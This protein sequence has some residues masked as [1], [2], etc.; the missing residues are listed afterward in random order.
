MRKPLLV[1]LC[2]LALA[3]P[4]EVEAAPLCATGTLQ[5]Y[6]GLTA[7]GCDIGSL[8]VANFGLWPL[9]ADATPIDPNALRIVPGAGTALDFVLDEAVVDDFLQVRFRFTVGGAI[10]SQADLSLSGASATDFGVVSSTVDICE[11]F[12]ANEPTGCPGDHV[13][14][15]VL[16]DALGP[17]S[18]A[19]E[20]IGLF[21]FFDVFAE[22]SIDGGGLLGSAALDGPVRLEFQTAAVPEPATLFL[23]TS[24]ILAGVARR[25]RARMRT[26]T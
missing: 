25:R 6:I 5:D 24:G 1:V 7:T 26:R 9:S 19:S 10:V 12:P 8:T 2:G 17:I 3:L 16:E 4:R 22:I 14:L 11:D 13:I 23:V 18:P 21:S 20:P 15:T